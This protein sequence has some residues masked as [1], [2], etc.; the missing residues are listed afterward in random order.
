MDEFEEFYVST[1]AR[2]FRTVLAVS[3][4]RAV[5]EDAVAEAYARALERW[6]HVLAHPNPAGWVTVTAMN[7]S[8]SR[9][10]A[11]VRERPHGLLSGRG[12]SVSDE[13]PE[14][15]RAAPVVTAVR[16]LPRRQREVVALRVVGEL[17]AA[18]V[19]A[20]LGISVATVHVHLHRG[21]AALRQRLSDPA[22]TGTQDKEMVK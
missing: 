11:L 19:A 7:V 8:R 16:E 21:L 17:S 1:K 4:D 2:V 12:G 10:R 13:A 6:R 3:G 22:G 9:W 20:V 15:G 18:E 5:A 14:P